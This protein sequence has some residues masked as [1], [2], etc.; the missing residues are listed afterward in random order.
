MSCI[1]FGLD[2]LPGAHVRETLIRFSKE[3]AAR[4]PLSAAAVEPQVLRLYGLLLCGSQTLRGEDP[5]PEV[6]DIM[7]R[8][9]ITR[10]H[11]EAALGPGVQRQTDGYLGDGVWAVRWLPDGRRFREEVTAQRAYVLAV[12]GKCGAALDLWYQE[13]GYDQRASLRAKLANPYHVV[14]GHILV[15]AER[16]LS[17]ADRAILALQPHEA[18]ALYGLVSTDRMRR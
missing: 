10:A 16:W 17:D 4:L 13:R 11:I 12:Q 8:L 14:A 1:G 9:D 6:A 3:I 2:S 7:R 18:E 5:A 15:G